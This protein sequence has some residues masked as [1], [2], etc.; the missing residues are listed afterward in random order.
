MDHVAGFDGC[1]PIE[2]DAA[3]FD[4]RHHVARWS[5]KVVV[6]IIGILDLLMILLASLITLAIH[7]AVGI[8]VAGGDHFAIQSALIAAGISRFMLVK[9]KMYDL[10]SLGNFP[11]KPIRLCAAFGAGLFVVMSIFLAFGFAQKF[12][13]SWFPL[14]FVTGITLLIVER[15]AARLFLRRRVKQGYFQSN[16]AVYGS[17]YIS[18][19][20]HDYLINEMDGIRFM[21]VFDD[22]QDKIRVDTYGLKMSGNLDDLI[23]AGREGRIDQI[24][25]T[26]PQSAAKRINQIVRALEQLPVHIHVCTHV[27]SD[28]IDAALRGNNVSTIGPIGLLNVKRK[29]LADWGP[30]V[31]KVED[32]FFGGLLMVASLPLFAVVALAIK[33]TSKGPVFFIQR[34]H[35]LNHKVINVYKFRTMRTMENGSDVRQASRDD[36]RVTSVGWFL[37]RTS[38]DELP[39]VIN[40]LKGE[41][42]LVGPRPHAVVHNEEYG[43]RL[44]RYSNRHQVKPGITGWAQV[45]GFRGETKDHDLMKMRV[46]HDLYYITHWSFWFDLKIMLMTP[47]Y[48]LINRNA[49]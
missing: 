14:W 10:H 15:G 40:V 28:I 46:M 24:I 49:Y 32:Y 1:G 44:E 45:N 7:K 19:K 2:V 25:I 34:R 23:C 4:R 43:D 42:S 21:G 29:P 22:R 27:S 5:R 36:S 48:G 37:R 31:K 17:G 13:A 6:D 26:L 20:L 8:Y 41:M 18:R 30:L 33:A 39:Q 38:L 35:G 9:G 12:H 47:I 16:L 11:V 3:P